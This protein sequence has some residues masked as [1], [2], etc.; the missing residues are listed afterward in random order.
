VLTNQETVKTNC[1][2]ISR[3]FSFKK[4]SLSSRIVAIAVC[5]T[6]GVQFTQMDYSG[7]TRDSK[8][9]IALSEKKTFR[10][11]WGSLRRNK[12]S[13]SGTKGF[14]FILEKSYTILK[15]LDYKSFCMYKR[16]Y[17]DIYIYIYIYIYIC[18]CM[19]VCVF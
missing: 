14:N 16:M 12:Y 17:V 5:I 9:A 8:P 15:W 7:I 18:V 11:K 2:L 1:I 3:H 13:K 6:L 4:I 10:I 19:C